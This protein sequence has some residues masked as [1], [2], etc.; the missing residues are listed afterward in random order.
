L[1]NIPNKVILSA[2]LFLALSFTACSYEDVEVERVDNVRIESLDKS[3]IS[4]SA[5]LFV[6]NPNG[7]KVRVTET[8]ADLFLDGR[9]AGKAKLRKNLVIPSRFKGKV[10]A[11]VRTDFEGGSLSL[12]PI[13]MGAA[14]KRKVN[15]RADGYLKAKSFVIGQKFDFDYTHEA[16]F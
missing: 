15:L 7:Y 2:T 6:T 10:T 3:G 11:Y 14:V 16:K 13:I 9:M 12:L 1:L 8:N 5:E 4:F